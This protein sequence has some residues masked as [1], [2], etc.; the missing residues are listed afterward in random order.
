MNNVP[1][2]VIHWLLLAA[3]PAVG[4]LFLFLIKR[5]FTDFEHKI[6]SIFS[7]L[8]DTIDRANKQHTDIE[9]IK[10][11]LDGLERVGRKRRS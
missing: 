5:T 4:S 2:S 7:K 10:Q 3:V 9:L 6:A 1:D 8:E 11:R